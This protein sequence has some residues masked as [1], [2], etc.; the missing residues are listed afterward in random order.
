MR[1]D[2]IIAPAANVP[3]PMLYPL[4][5]PLLFALD[6]ETAHDMTF[7]G[8][9]AAAR[10]GVA[11]L[12]IP[13]VPGRSR[14]RSMGLR[15][16]N[17]V[18]LAAGLDKNAAHID[19]L[20]AL[21]FGI[22]NAVPSRRARS[23]AIRSRG[24]SGCRR[25]RRSSTGWAS[26]TT[27]LERSSRTPVARVIAAC[28]DSTSARTSIRRS[29]A[30]PTTTSRACAAATR[31]RRTSP[32]TSARR[33]RRDCATC[34]TKPRSRKLVG[35]LKSEQA[36]SQ[37]STASTRRSRS[38][39]RRTWTRRR[40]TGIAKLLVRHRVDGVI[41]TNTTLARDAVEGLPHA[42]RI[43]RPLGAPAA[44]AGDAK[45]CSGS[46]EPSTARCRSSAS[47]ASCRAT[48]AKEKIDAGAAL[49][50]IYTGL[51]YRGPELV[52]ECVRATSRRSV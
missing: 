36:S 51:I 44:R 29:I 8:L 46:R 4:F 49:V 25:R 12:A 5:R 52:A 39:S 19:G 32:S 6:P 38:R 13:R 26:T 24:C 47:A 2:V 33:T 16:P 31:A 43:R 30:P 17:R 34:S 37:S 45:S 27:G 3:L 23:P 18:G 20:A 22:S 1:R 9:D 10:L 35:A 11:R 14:S 41:A 40:S 7:G 48:D 28:S 15:F 42:E 50:Q 21:G